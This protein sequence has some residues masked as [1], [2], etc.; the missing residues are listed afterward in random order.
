M[1]T[2]L[3]VRPPAVAGMFYP[4]DPEELRNEIT[5][6]MSLAETDSGKIREANAALWGAI[7][8]HA[9]YMYSGYTAA[10]AYVL[11]QY[12]SVDTIILV[13]PS[14]REYFDFISVFPGQSYET[15]LG[16]VDVDTEMR[17]A[18]LASS[19][20]IKA[21]LEGHRNEHA[22]EVQ[23]PFLQ[24]MFSKFKILPVIMGDQRREFCEELGKALTTIAALKQTI[25]VASSDLSHY[26]SSDVARSLDAVAIDC[27]G[28]MR[29]LDLMRNLETEQAEACG[30]GG[31]V[32]LLMAAR[33]M[34]VPQC[35]ILHA[36][37]S[38]D[39][40]GERD[41]VVGYV[42]AALWKAH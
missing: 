30:G 13:G 29:E 19:P 26:Y 5:G 34:N 7:V 33:R 17:E 15:P 20:I 21:S 28:H 24:V 27:I 32:S 10:R 36:C 2:H 18:L 14:H 41:K 9:G 22:L 31:I 12:A 39:I 42:S 4:E 1:N 11:M 23:I 3:Y 16:V 35:E 8:P 25:L 40:T 37:N 38:G 6:M